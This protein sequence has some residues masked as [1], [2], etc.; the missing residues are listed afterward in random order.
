MNRYTTILDIRGTK[1]YNSPSTRLLYLHLVL[2]A[3]Y[4]QDDQDQVTA[5][6]R[7]LARE[8]GMTI[9][10]TRHAIQVL[11][12]LGLLQRQEGKW[13]VLKFVKPILA[14]KGSNKAV[15]DGTEEMAQLTEQR[16]RL[17]DE[18]AKLKRWYADAQQRGDN[19]SATAIYKDAQRISRQL[20]ALG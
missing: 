8:C 3:G 5:S 16:Q 15:K 10:A 17:T 13:I 20:K 4:H 12:E 1:A 6:I 14:A 9:S 11:T 7:T 2:T 19:D 18:L